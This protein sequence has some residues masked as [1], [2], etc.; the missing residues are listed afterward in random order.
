MR[1]H[2]RGWGLAVLVLLARP[3]A[4]ADGGTA[5]ATAPAEVDDRLVQSRAVEAVIWGMPAVNAELMAVE[6][7]K[8]GG[9]INQFVYWSRP[10]DWKNQTLTPNPDSI[11]FM[12]FYSTKD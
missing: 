2:A 4:A 10:A 11:Y 8:A 5:R 12:S 3:G 1:T 6:A 7:V 9:E